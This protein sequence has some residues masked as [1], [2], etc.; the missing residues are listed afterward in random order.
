[1]KYLR[2]API[3][4]PIPTAKY[5]DHPTFIILFYAGQPK[6]ES[7]LNSDSFQCFK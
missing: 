1:M 7:E 5:I 4:P 6:K 3:I 2:K